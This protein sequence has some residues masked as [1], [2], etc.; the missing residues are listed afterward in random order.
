MVSEHNPKTVKI[1]PE[2]LKAGMSAFLS[3]DKRFEDYE[4]VVER[5]WREMNHASLK[6][7]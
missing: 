2:M 3:F 4:D 1:T 6:E 5:I 7:T